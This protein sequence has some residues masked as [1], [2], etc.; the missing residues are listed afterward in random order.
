[1][2]ADCMGCRKPGYSHAAY[3]PESRVEELRERLD[4]A[5]RVRRC[6]ELAPSTADV[7]IA[8]YRKR[9]ADS[10]THRETVTP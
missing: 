2:T 4:D 6:I 8:G 1:M 5:E 7:A 10:A 3:C 9:H